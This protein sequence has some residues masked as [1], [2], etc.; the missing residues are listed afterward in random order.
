M[1][2]ACLWAEIAPCLPA[3][4]ASHAC[5]SASSGGERKEPVHSQ[6]ALIWYS[7]N[8]L[9]CEPD[10]LHIRAFCGKILFFFLSLAIPQFGLLYQVSSLRL[11]SW[12][13]GHSGLVLTLSTDD[14]AHASQSSP[15]SLMLDMS[16]WATSLLAVAVRHVFCGVFWGFLF[17]SFFLSFFFPSWLCCPLRFQNSPQTSLWEGFLLFGNF[18]SFTTPS[19]GQV[20]VPNSFLSLFVFYILSYI[21]LKRMGCLSGC[22]VSSA[23]VQKLFCGNYSAFKFDEFVGEKVV[24][25]S[26]SPPSWDRPD[27]FVFKIQDLLLPSG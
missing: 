11:S 23:S 13:S 27:T 4:T 2:D 20:S 21:F 6:L 10:R 12:H 14:A 7:L 8:P 26:Y 17:L 24:S 5:L 19:Q 1:K 16:V 18:S 22:L 25:L 15:R 3:L 9:F